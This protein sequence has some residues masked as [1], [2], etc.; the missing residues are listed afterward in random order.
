[1]KKIIVV[2]FFAFGFSLLANAQETALTSKGKVVILYENGT[3]KYADVSVSGE[4]PAQ[5]TGNTVQAAIEE[6][7]ISDEPLVLKEADV[8]KITF[9]EGPSAKLLKYFKDKNIVRCDFTLRSKDGKATL[10][11]DWKIMTGEAYSYFGYIKKETKLSLELLGGQIVDLVYMNEF[12]PK[13][14]SQYGFST[15]SAQLDL[16]EDQLKLLQNKIVMKATMNWSRRA[17]E[18]KV[19]NPSYFIK[20]IP[21][22][23]E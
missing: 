8:E 12:E 9:I 5:Q 7:R 10:Q 13:E 22:I 17:E 2:C 3:W 11:T 19:V 16:T 4:N 20:A 6:T 15:Y 14:F 18:Y 21:Q 1:M 23:T